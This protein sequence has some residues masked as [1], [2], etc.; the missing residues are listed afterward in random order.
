M[1]KMLKN[2]VEA[3][4]T[5][6]IYDALRCRIIITDGDKFY[7]MLQNLTNPALHCKIIK[8]LNNME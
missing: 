2:G 4:G 1:E 7:K 8:I 3:K 5:Y 6:R